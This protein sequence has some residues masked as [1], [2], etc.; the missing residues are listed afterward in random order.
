MT[1]NFLNI[2]FLTLLL[3]ACSTTQNLSSSNNLFTV[4]DSLGAMGQVAVTATSSTG[5]QIYLLDL[6]TK[7]VS[8][9]VTSPG[10]NA[11]PAFSPDG[12]NLL[13]V[14]DRNGTSELYLA[15]SDGQNAQQITFSGGQKFY[16]FWS[17]DGEK[18]YFTHA[19]SNT[20]SKVMLGGTRWKL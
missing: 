15:S 14:S 11:Y 8:D 2:F 19:K 12:K 6:N 13:F 16:P 17:P 20:K 7:T 9:L 5:Q 10:N 1:K 3:S 4:G 18:A